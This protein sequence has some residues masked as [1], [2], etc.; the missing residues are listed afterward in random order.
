MTFRANHP[1]G[2]PI[3]EAWER[4][5]VEGNENHGEVAIGTVAELI[6]AGGVEGR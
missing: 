3:I 5:C 1:D 6:E 2:E 4:T